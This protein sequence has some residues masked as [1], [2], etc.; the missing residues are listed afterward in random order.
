[1]RLEDMTAPWA[2]GVD[3]GFEDVSRWKARRLSSVAIA[4]VQPSRHFL[5]PWHL[6]LPWR[7]CWLTPV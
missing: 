7:L 6:V 2:E 1:M 4:A 3:G 5:R